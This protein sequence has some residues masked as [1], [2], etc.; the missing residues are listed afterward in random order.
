MGGGEG[1]PAALG[2][3]EYCSFMLL[4]LVCKE[5]GSGDPVAPDS[6]VYIVMMLTAW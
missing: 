5:Q 2:S 6:I 4:V 1:E 3:S